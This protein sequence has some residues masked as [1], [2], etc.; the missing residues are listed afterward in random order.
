MRNTKKQVITTKHVWLLFA[1]ADG[2]DLWTP[3]DIQLLSSY[4]E[5]SAVYEKHL[6]Y[7]NSTEGC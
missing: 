1:S 3:G 7:E 2:F 4:Y 6:S 5:H